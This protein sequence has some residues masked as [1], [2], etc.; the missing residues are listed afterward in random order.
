M[1]AWTLGISWISCVSFVLSEVLFYQVDLTVF[2]L[3]IY[4]SAMQQNIVLCYDY[5]EYYCKNVSCM[6]KNIVR[7]R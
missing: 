3:T 7:T 2:E 5:S 1:C 4:Q 6:T